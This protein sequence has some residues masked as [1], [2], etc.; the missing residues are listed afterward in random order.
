MKFKKS[1]F[2]KLLYGFLLFVAGGIFTTIID[3]FTTAFYFEPVLQVKKINNIKSNGVIINEFRLSN[4]GNSRANDILLEYQKLQSDEVSIFQ[5]VSH[6]VLADNKILIPSLAPGEIADLIFISSS[7]EYDKVKNE[8]GRELITIP[9]I[10]S[11][12]FLEGSNDDVIYID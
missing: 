4:E 10:S 7:E 5:N 6:E 8:I 3:Q 9:G 11:I 1:K 12:D 2:K